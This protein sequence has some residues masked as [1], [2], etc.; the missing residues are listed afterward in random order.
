MKSAY[1]I[2]GK[3]DTNEERETQAFFSLAS[4]IVVALL[5]LIEPNLNYLSQGPCTLRVKQGT[6]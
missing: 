2:A 3:S 5:G 6:V 1:F 4:L